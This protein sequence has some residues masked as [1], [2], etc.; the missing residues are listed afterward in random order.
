M[1]CLYK[2]ALRPFLFRMDPERAHDSSKKFLRAAQDSRFMRGFFS[3]VFSYPWDQPVSVGGVV[4]PNPVGLAAGYD[5]NG[6]LLG[7]IP[8]FGFGFVEVGTFTPH[9]QSGNPLPRIFRIPEKQ[10]VLNRLGFNNCG[11]QEAVQH[12]KKFPVTPIPIGINIGKGV[13]TPLE[14]AAEDYLTCFKTLFPYADYFVLNISSPNTAELKKLHEPSRLRNLLAT[15]TLE[16]ERRK[17]NAKLLFIKISPDLSD[18]ELSDVVGIAVSYKVGIVC[19]N[20]TSKGFRVQGSGVEFFDQPPAPFAALRVPAGTPEESSVLASSLQ[21]LEFGGLSG[22]PLKETS[23]QMIRRVK[24]ISAGK[25]PI[26]GVGGIFTAADAKEKLEAG[27]DLV[28]VYTGLIYEG[29]GL[30]KSILRGLA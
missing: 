14:Q 29:P 19:C 22:K 15:V 16:N 3:Q 9:P 6:E 17:T 30:V 1:G 24:E 5:K 20:T 2:L 13:E 4:F 21:P 28:Q 18:Q 23:T 8:S 27:A 25:I 10:A 11:A 26:I 7:I 12:L